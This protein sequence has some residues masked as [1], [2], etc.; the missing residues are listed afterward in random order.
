MADDDDLGMSTLYQVSSGAWWSAPLP[1]GPPSI[2]SLIECD[3]GRPDLS[4]ATGSGSSFPDHTD[5]HIAKARLQ[6]FLGWLQGRDGER[7]RPP[8]IQIGASGLPLTG[9]VHQ[10]VSAPVAWTNSPAAI[11]SPAA[12]FPATYCF[13]AMRSGRAPS[14]SAP[15]IKS[16]A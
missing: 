13:A 14:A 4:C 12:Q 3:Q 5:F 15:S 6:K 10:R 8:P 16:F 1:C 9:S 11:W 7:G 2:S